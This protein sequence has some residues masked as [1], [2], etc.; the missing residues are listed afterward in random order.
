MSTEIE[1][2]L[3]VLEQVKNGKPGEEVGISKRVKFT[4]NEVQKDD[5]PSFSIGSQSIREVEQVKNRLKG[6]T[7]VVVED[8]D[9][10]KR[11]EYEMS[12]E[13][14]LDYESEPP[15]IMT[16]FRYWGERFREVNEV[17]REDFDKLIEWIQ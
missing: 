13:I 11:T 9:T 8:P 14:I 4:K 1:I 12:V 2:E 6:K 16:M 3:K 10:Q 7:T 5:K 17:S 15:I